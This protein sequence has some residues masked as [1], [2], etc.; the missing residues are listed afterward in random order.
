M[1]LD[2]F[3]QLNIFSISFLLLM[4]SYMTCSTFGSKVLADDDFGDTGFYSLATVYV[5]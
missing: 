2:N 5:V 3:G 4:I 1:I